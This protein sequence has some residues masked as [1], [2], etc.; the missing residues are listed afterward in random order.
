MLNFFLFLL[1][2]QGECQAVV[3]SF[4]SPW[5]P[6]D[7]S[8]WVYHTKPSSQQSLSPPKLMLSGMLSP[9]VT[10]ISQHTRWKIRGEEDGLDL[11]VL[12]LP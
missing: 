8:F 10:A 11:H 4:I 6:L 7:V 12:A 3:L 2:A 5:L 1:K 9:V